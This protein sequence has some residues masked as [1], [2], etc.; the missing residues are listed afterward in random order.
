MTWRGGLAFLGISAA[1]WW[2]G[3]LAYAAVY[4][5]AP[6][7]YL[8]GDRALFEMGPDPTGC[9]S[10]LLCDVAP[11]DGSLEPV[12]YSL[13]TFTPTPTPTPTSTAPATPAA[14][15]TSTSTPTVTSTATPPPTAT[16]TLTATPTV[17]RPAAS[18]YVAEL[19]SGGRAEISMTAT[20][21]DVWLV[22]IL[23]ALLLL[24]VFEFL[25]WLRGR[26]TA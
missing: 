9:W 5:P 17:T 11:C 23:A 16:A 1:L 12:C 25:R 13:V 8:I 19:P 14:T 6:G 20:A 18:V 3:R 2:G 21:G 22:L 4:P 24:R 10:W 15:A 26:F 7:I